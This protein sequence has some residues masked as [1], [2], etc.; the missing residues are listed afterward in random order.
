[1]KL[2]DQEIYDSWRDAAKRDNYSSII[3]PSG[4]DKDLYAEGGRHYAGK[5]L[6]YVKD[7][8][9]VMDYGCGNGRILQYI[10]DPKVGID[11]VPEAARMVNGYTPSEFTGKVDVIY[12]VCVFIHNSYEIGCNILQWMHNRLKNGGKLLLQ[13]PIYETSKNPLHPMDVGVWTE[14]MFIDATKG[15]EIIELHKNAGSFTFEAIGPN[16]FEFHVLVK[17]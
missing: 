4:Y 8:D 11:I 3:H 5:I 17:K 2:V 6:K 9:I 7:G 12:S 15:F 14:K 1:M 13:M 10:R 16:H